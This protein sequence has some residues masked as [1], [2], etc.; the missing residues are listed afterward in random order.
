M[1]LSII[2]PTLNEE[3]SI[4]RTVE[5]LR[6]CFAGLQ[7]V[8]VI[9]VDGCS[10]DRT[11][12]IAKNAGAVTVIGKRGR[13]IQMNQGASVSTAPLLF[14]LHA[15]T[16]PPKSLLSDISGAV[17]EG[18]SAGCYRLSFDYEHWFLRLNSWFTRFDINSFRYGDQGLFVTRDIFEK[19]GGFDE[20]LGLMEDHEIIRRMKHLTKF[21]IF[22]KF[23]KTSARKY[24]KNGIYRLQCSFVLIYLFY[25]LGFSQEKLLTIYQSLIR[26]ERGD[27]SEVLVGQVQYTGFPPVSTK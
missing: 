17:Q 22:P 21:K 18:Y 25:K 27:D 24:L 15:D 6:S 19:V 4:G 16:L 23:V 8:E 12:M 11:V 9:V 20:S 13:A 26:D 5:Y 7:Q 3:D 14:F 2:I 1:I 10:F